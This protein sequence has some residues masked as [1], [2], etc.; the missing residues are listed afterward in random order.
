MGMTRP[1]FVVQIPDLPT[2]AWF[3]ALEPFLFARQ[4]RVVFSFEKCQRLLPS[5]VAILGGFARRILAADREV[6]FAWDTCRPLVLRNLQQ[7][8]FSAAFGGPP[9]IKVGH[10]I[11]YREDAAEN[12]DGIVG[13][14]QGSWLGRGW[15]DVSPKLSAAIVGRVW[16]IYSNAFEHG[17]SDVGV[18]SCGHHYLSG[19]LSLTVVDLGRGIPNTVAGFLGTADYPPEEALRWAFKRGTTTNR[20]RGSRGLGLDLL[21]EF[22]RVNDGRLECFSGSAEAIITRSEETFR[23]SAHPFRG[24]LLTITFRCDNRHYRF[25]TEVSERQAPLF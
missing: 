10:T 25:A 11:P 5:A 4:E 17:H 2:R 16:E 6:L 1:A 13:Y 19:E 12:P 22:V 24:T 21:K 8:G 20:E 15:I 3:F 9:R 14:L 7:T 23:R 18:L